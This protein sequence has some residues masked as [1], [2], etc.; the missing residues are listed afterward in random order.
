MS[1]IGWKFLGDRSTATAVFDFYGSPD[2]L[3]ADTS[4]AFAGHAPAGQVPF[5][6]RN[7]GNL[8]RESEF[9]RCEER[10]GEAGGTRLCGPV[11]RD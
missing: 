3:K 8:R 6:F 4:S 5:K 7:R 2:N 11:A 9:H 10:T 1:L